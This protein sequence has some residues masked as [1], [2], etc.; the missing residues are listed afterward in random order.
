MQE[1]NE[2]VILAYVAMRAAN[3]SMQFKEAVANI[4]PF[5]D[6]DEVLSAKVS[7]FDIW[8]FLCSS[9][10]AKMS[11]DVVKHAKF[12]ETIGAELCFL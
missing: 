8:C 4:T 6:N 5:P 2:R 10:E 3:L 12:Q 9:I 1:E 11:A 7:A